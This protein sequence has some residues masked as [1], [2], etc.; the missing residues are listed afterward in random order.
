MA[1]I[2]CVDDERAALESMEAALEAS[3]HLTVGVRNADAALTVL[4]RGGI[5]LVISDYR[6][7][8]SSG[9]GLLQA[10]RSRGV[11]VPLIMVTG[12][13]SIEHAVGAMKEGAVDYITKPWTV[14]GLNIAADQALEVVRLR[15]ENAQLKTR[16]EAAEKGRVAAE[17]RSAE[18]ET[19]AGRQTQ[20]ITELEKLLARQAEEN[21]DLLDELLKA[22]I[23][24]LRMERQML[25]TKLA[26]LADD[27][28]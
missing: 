26:D 5:D 13:G 9:V 24:R 2:L 25:Q 21:K 27:K 20:R 6:M 14:E 23:T 22:R 11:D 17:H 12:H 3:G 10:M 15:K 18:A 19:A 1:R 4:D 7:P 8:G 16:L 28:R